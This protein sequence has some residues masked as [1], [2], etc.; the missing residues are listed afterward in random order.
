[1]NHSIPA[2]KDSQV[3]LVL[4]FNLLVSLAIRNNFESC[5]RIL[6]FIGMV[7]KSSEISLSNSLSFVLAF[8]KPN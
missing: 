7:L 2:N 8:W 6:T 1:M 3:L 4:L 5:N